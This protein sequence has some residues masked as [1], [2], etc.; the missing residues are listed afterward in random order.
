LNEREVVGPV[1][2]LHGW[3]APLPPHPVPVVI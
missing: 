3:S 2:R 1:A